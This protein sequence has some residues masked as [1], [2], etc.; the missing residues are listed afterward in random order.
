M[1]SPGVK[2]LISGF[3][4]L[5][6]RRGRGSPCGNVAILEPM[7]VNN[8]TY[9]ECMGYYGIKNLQSQSSPFGMTKRWQNDHTFCNLSTFYIESQCFDFGT[10]VQIQQLKMVLSKMQGSL[11]YPFGGNQTI[12][13]YD[14]YGNFRDFPQYN[15]LF[16]FVWVVKE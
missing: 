12:Q 7:Q 5:N 14:M 16:D 1:G 4:N 6:L 8:I 2:T 10:S 15:A 9:V 3:I 11:Y 13:I